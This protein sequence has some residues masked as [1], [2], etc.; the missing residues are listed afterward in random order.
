VA[1][2]PSTNRARPLRPCVAM[3]MMLACSS[4]GFQA[5]VGA[6]SP[7]SAIFDRHGSLSF[8]GLAETHHAASR[9]PEK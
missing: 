9:S 2:L 3:A 5:I 8:A 7:K 4:R 6:A 1:T